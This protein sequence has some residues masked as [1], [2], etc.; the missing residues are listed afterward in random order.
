MPFEIF[1]ESY[2]SKVKEV[3]LGLDPH[4]LIVGGENTPPFHFFEGDWPNRQRFGLEI[5]DQIPSDW[6][7]AI[8]KYFDDVFDDPVQWAR[9]CVGTYHAE[10]VCLRLAGT[11][12]FQL[13]TSPEEAGLLVKAVSEAVVVP[14]VVYGS[15]HEEKDREV[16]TQVAEMNA[17]KNLFLGPATK[18]NYEPIG[19][20]AEQYGHGIILWTA[21]EVPEAKELHIK[22]TKLLSPDRVLLDPLTPAL[23][24]GMEYAYSAME[25]IKLAG[26][27][28][29]DP[30]FQIPLVAN[31]GKACWETAEAKASEEQGLL[32]ETITGLSYLLAGADLLILRNPESLNLLKRIVEGC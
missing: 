20:A 24:Y 29:G 9:K 15:G 11:D 25:R 16:L 23:G 3:K 27:S 8:K 17:G 13:N 30:H 14:V 12:P 7:P 6:S 10:T 4:S 31:I 2:K 28:F 22:L 21:I 5:L 26:I 18:K 19:K 1:K 32:W